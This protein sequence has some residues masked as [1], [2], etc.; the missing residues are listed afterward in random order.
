MKTH[1]QIILLLILA[2]SA[3]TARSS[4]NTDAAG[5]GGDAKKFIDEANESLLK[6]NIEGSQAG[7]VSETYITDDTSALNARSNQRVIEAT[8]RLAKDAVRFDK[9]ET[10]PDL[11]RE[12]DLLK[13]SLV[14]ATPSDP[15]ESEELTRIAANLDGEYGK[16]KW[17]P[18]PKKPESCLDINKITD[19][20]RDSRD[21]KQLREVWE[22][23]HTISPPM[24][25]DYAR[26]V[27]LSNKGARELGF[28]DSGAMWRAK[29]DMPP[30]AF[31]K[32]VDRLWDQ[33]R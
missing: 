31:A 30:D 9:A 26:F 3:C 1:L 14:M 17:C 12:L 28:A 29:Y 16:G 10:T 21:E 6:L 32:E 19:I 23:W 7:W 20:M 27:E 18:D 25:K 4:E 33:V 24:R 15:K 5:G 13:V 22:G 2:M 11:R 8:E